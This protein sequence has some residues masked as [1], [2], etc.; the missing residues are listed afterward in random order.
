[1][2]QTQVYYASGRTAEYLSKIIHDLDVHRIFIVTGTNLYSLS[3]AK[4]VLEK[5]LEGLDV[6]YYHYPS[7][8][9]TIED[10]RDSVEKSRAH[11]SQ[12]IIG[13]GGGTAMD[14][15]KATRAFVPNLGNPADYIINKN[16][17][18]N[19]SQQTLVQIPTT[20]GT[21]SEITQ[22]AVVYIEG[23][24][25]SLDDPLLKAGYCILD[26]Q[27]TTSMTPKLT[28]VTALD[29][30]SQAIESFWSIKS[31]E[32]SRTSSMEALKLI[33]PRFEKLASELT[34]EDRDALLTASHLAGQ[35]IGVTRTTAAHA[36]SY[37]LTSKYDVPH[38]LAVA[39]TLPSFFN[40]NYEVDAESNQDPRGVKFVR[41]HIEIIA[42]SL[43]TDS[44]NECVNWLKT[45]IDSFGISLRLRD[46]GI[47][48]DIIENVIVP[49]FNEE[50]GKN[51]PRKVTKDD[52]TKILLEIW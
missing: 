50:R 9:P 27:L 8:N 40:F 6:K 39:L 52:L 2:T 45:T 14:I 16:P 32:E 10:I 28:V 20:S 19:P 51:N 13:L 30:L 37:S 5:T 29:A 33:A 25:Y 21:G 43:E 31:T 36:I 48:Q 22:F 17:F 47:E 42:K 3:G 7:P 41:E 46:Y 11:N 12:I 49:S 24:K 38:G 4:Q 23:T 26:P 1:M 35:A 34:L 15:A 44:V 18:S